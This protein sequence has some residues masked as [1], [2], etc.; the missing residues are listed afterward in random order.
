M[1]RAK[2]EYESLRPGHFFLRVTLPVLKNLSAFLMALA[3]ACGRQETVP[4]PPAPKPAFAPVSLPLV[5]FDPALPDHQTIGRVLRH[6]RQNLDPAS[7]ARIRQLDQHALQARGL[8]DIRPLASLTGLESLW[9]QNNRIENPAPLASLTNLTQLFLDQNRLTALSPLAK[10][11]RLRYLG[12]SQNALTTMGGVEHLAALEYLNLSG[13]ELSNLAPLAPLVRLTELHLSDNRVTDLASLNALRHLKR[14]SLDSNALA[15]LRGLEGCAAL[16][17]VSLSATGINNLQPL[18]RASRLRKLNLVRNNIVDLAPIL[19]PVAP[20]VHLAEIHLSDNRVTNLSPLGSFQ[21]LKR[22]FLDRNPLASLDGLEGCVALEEVSLSDTGVASL[23]SLARASRLRKL[24]LVRNDI[25]DLS[26]LQDCAAMEE[27][28]IDGNLLTTLAPVAEMKELRI[29]NISNNRFDS[30][31]PL[32][33]LTRLESLRASHNSLGTLNGLQA[34]TSLRRLDLAHNAI[35][36]LSSLGVLRELEELHL[37]ENS[38]VNLAPLRA[39]TRLQ[40]LRLKYNSVNDLSHLARMT[41]L[42]ALDLAGN[43]VANLRGLEQCVFLETLDLSGNDITDLSPLAHLTRLRELRLK[44]NQVSDLSPLAG[45]TNLVHLDL[46]ENHA[47]R[48][49]PLSALPLLKFLNLE[50]NGI[51]TIDGLEHCLALENLNLARNPVTKFDPIARLPEL[52]QLMVD[53]TKAKTVM[54]LAGLK[55][56]RTLDFE[57]STGKPRGEI[58]RLRAAL[59]HCALQQVGL[60]QKNADAGVGHILVSPLS[61]TTTYLLDSGGRVAHTWP[62][63]YRPRLSACLLDDGSILRPYQQGADNP[64]QH[65][66]PVPGGGLRRIAWDGTVLWHFPFVHESYRLHHDIEPLPNGNVLAIAHHRKTAAE[67]VA[68][69][70]NPKLLARDELWPDAILEIKPTGPASGE[71]VWAWHVWDHLIQDFDRTKSNYGEVAEHPG[72]IDLNFARRGQANWTHFNSIDY[73]PELDQIIISV[74]NFNEIWII[75]HNLTLAEAAGRRGDLLYR[76]GNP[77]AHRQGLR[78]DRKLFGQHD[79]RW[80]ETGHPGEGHLL[81]FNNGLRRRAGPWSSVLELVPPLTANGSYALVPGQ[82]RGPS[83]PV[84][85]Y[86]APNKT[87]FYSPNISGAQRLPNGHTLICS[88]APGHVF[89]VTPIGQT[90]WHYI[91]PHHARARGPWGQGGTRARAA[92][93][94]ANRTPALRRPLFRAIPIP[95]EHPALKRLRDP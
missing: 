30:L 66:P 56:L 10:L 14:L 74:H 83:E 23:Q 90:V 84:W 49:Q 68:A 64:F 8:R 24:N 7:F 50:N 87:D 65:G 33:G 91:N 31:A 43:R 32:A 26:P 48:L 92:A 54:P 76:W 16:E 18:A 63:R 2:R 37:D 77:A 19:A 86:T 71:I 25:A 51:T 67:A 47:V 41:G 28:E 9:L 3:L 53:A 40:V 78:R 44:D 80:I 45:L 4:P 62:G 13:N 6:G 5:G 46:A 35:R 1:K 75:D 15:S 89:E 11:S 60:I 39:H 72:R 34:S 59:P 38:V 69:G 61:S 88:G 52:R 95:N 12:A 20:L 82:P 94:A 29:L 93:A 27:L 85:T 57:W 42:R 79:A 22:L 21:N 17:E 81:V 36:D 58:D 55:S 73:H 70:R